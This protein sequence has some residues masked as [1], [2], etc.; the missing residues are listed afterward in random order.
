MGAAGRA[1]AQ[2]RYSWDAIAPRLVEIYA[3]AIAGVTAM[4]AAP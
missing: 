2:E 4:V 3:S 1:L